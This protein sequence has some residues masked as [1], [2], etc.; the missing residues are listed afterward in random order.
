M[1]EGSSRA[2]P[3]A[4]PASA[5]ATE[6]GAPSA[7]GTR[8]MRDLSNGPVRVLCDEIGFPFSR[9]LER[10]DVFVAFVRE[11]VCEV[12][13]KHE[14]AQ[15]LERLGAAKAS[16]GASEALSV[17]AAMFS[18]TDDAA[19]IAAAG[20]LH[21][22]CDRLNPE[23]AYPTDHL[24]DMLSSC[25]SAVRFGLERGKWGVGSR[26][27]AEAANHVW[28]QVYGIGRFDRYTS[29]WEKDWARQKLIE[30]LIS[31]LPEES[32]AGVCQGSEA[33]TAQGTPATDEP[34]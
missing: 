11:L 2:S 26:H 12:S 29:G 9:A 20:R 7:A 32:D 10:S 25:A 30:A 18:A 6:A 4:H 5:A 14:I 24:I 31:L 22:T 3:S 21:E 15:H 19:R 33:D 13:H 16:A 1:E 23:S 34:K 27:A 28:K 8:P 17:A